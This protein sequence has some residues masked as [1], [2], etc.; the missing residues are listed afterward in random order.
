MYKRPVLGLIGVVFIVGTDTLRGLGRDVAGQAACLTGAAL[1]A[2]AA[3]YGKRLSHV[4]VRA[5]ATGTMLWASLVLVPAAL[6]VEGPAMQ[7]PNLKA[8]LALL[9]LSFFCTGVALL[10]YF[11]L[12]RTLGSLGVASQSYLRAG[13]GVLLG[14]VVLGEKLTLPTAAGLIAAILGVALINWPGLDPLRRI[15]LAKSIE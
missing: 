11:R 9:V 3:I 2:A 6:V 4:G 8:V 15:W 5:S 14:V 13:V 12:L 7:L 1:Y 10:I